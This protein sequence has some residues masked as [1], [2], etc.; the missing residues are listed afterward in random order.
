MGIRYARTDLVPKR[1]SG[2]P[3]SLVCSGITRSSTVLPDSLGTASGVTLPIRTVF[4]FD[5]RTRLNSFSFKAA[6]LAL[7]SVRKD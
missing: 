6:M 7:N 2:A 5:N 4:Q 3:S 1:P